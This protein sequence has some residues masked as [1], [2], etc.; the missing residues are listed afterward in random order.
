MGP[1]FLLPTGTDDLLGSEKWGMGPT[2]VA[3]K[4]NGPWTV[5]ALVSHTW[6]VAGESDRN[7]VNL[8][9]MQPFLNYTTPDAWTFSL[10]TESSFNWEAEDW[11]VPINF[12]IKKLVHFA[13]QPVQFSAGVRF[14]LE[15]APG[16]PEDLG[17]RF[18]LTFLFPR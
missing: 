2:F 1:I 13:D 14:W 17:F 18:E 5:G 7:D 15:S 10:N 8:S 4:Q 9:Y 16:D 6:S 12:M 11:S 3:L